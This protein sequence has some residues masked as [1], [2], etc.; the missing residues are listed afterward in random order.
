VNVWIKIF[1]T[2]S[3]AYVASE[4]KVLF[5]LYSSKIW[6]VVVNIARIQVESGRQIRLQNMRGE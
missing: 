6:T 1:Q 4:I 5:L 3:L 2:D